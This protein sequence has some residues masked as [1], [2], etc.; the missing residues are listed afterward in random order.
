MSC[1]EC[2]SQDLRFKR[3][4]QED[5][6]D[7]CCLA[8]FESSMAQKVWGITSHHVTPD[9]TVIPCGCNHLYWWEGSSTVAKEVQ[10]TPFDRHHL[11]RNALCGFSKEGCCGSCNFLPSTELWSISNIQDLLKPRPNAYMCV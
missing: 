3:G 1:P 11:P 7:R 9:L 6:R 8:L 4:R 5:G 2:R 10:V